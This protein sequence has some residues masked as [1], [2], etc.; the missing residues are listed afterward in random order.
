[1]L[2]EGNTISFKIDNIEKEYLEAPIRKMHDQGESEVTGL[3]DTDGYK[4]SKV[5]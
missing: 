4:T 5:L 1:V 2:F 3:I